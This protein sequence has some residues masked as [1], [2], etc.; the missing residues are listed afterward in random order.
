MILR[1][2][3]DPGNIGPVSQK[4]KKKKSECDKRHFRKRARPRTDRV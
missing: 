4:K 1:P 3:T 2:K